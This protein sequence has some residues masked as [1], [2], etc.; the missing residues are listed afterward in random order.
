[1]NLSQAWAPHELALIPAQLI[2]DIGELLN[3]GNSN[4]KDEQF[5]KLVDNVMNTVYRCPKCA[6][7]HIEKKDQK[8]HFDTYNLEL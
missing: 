6:R 1:M 8:N 7:I 4:L 5:Y 3:G 2:E